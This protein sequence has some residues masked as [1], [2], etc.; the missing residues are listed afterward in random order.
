MS[1]YLA[2]SPL[3]RSN[4]DG[5]FLW[6]FP[7]GYPAWALPS[8]LPGGARTFLSDKIGAATRSPWPL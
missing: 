5:M 1:S 8:I 2:I 6:H 4:R 3:S 7:S